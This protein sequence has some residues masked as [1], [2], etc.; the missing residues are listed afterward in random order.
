VR[1][2]PRFASVFFEGRHHVFGFRE[3]P[4]AFE[5]WTTKITIHPDPAKRSKYDPRGEPDPIEAVVAAEARL[6]RYRT[7]ISLLRAGELESRASP[8]TAGAVEQITRAIWSHTEFSFDPYTGNI[9]QDNPCSTADHDRY[10]KRWVG[11]VLQK[12]TR[13][14][15]GA[16]ASSSARTQARLEQK[17]PES[18]LRSHAPPF[19]PADVIAL[20]SLSRA[21]DHLVFNHPEIRILCQIAVSVADARQIPFEEDAGLVVQVLGYD[22][23]ALPLRYFA[24]LVEQPDEPPLPESP[25]EAAISAEY[26]GVELPPDVQAYYDAVKL[27]ADTLIG[28]LQQQQVVARGHTMD[29]HLVQIAHSIWSHLE[30]YVHPPT[31]DVYNA[32]TRPMTK[33]WSG[34]V[35]E[36]PAEPQFHVKPTE[37]HGIRSTSTENNAGAQPRRRK[38]ASKRRKAAAK[39]GKA[40]AERR[41]TPAQASIEQAVAALWPDGVPNTMLL[42]TR[43]QMIARWQ[44]GN[45]VLAVSSKTVR[46]FLT[47]DGRFRE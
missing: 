36:A 31:G 23:P 24:H 7:L 41:K 16:N 11:V 26:F 47:A 12:P 44:K 20:G 38:T 10:I 5:R 34:V 29:G 15:Q 28:M 32:S 1:L 40:A 2:A 14:D 6:H 42:K 39:R 13:A 37:H 4:L 8:G 45:G 22:D 9:L 3:W 18:V 43:D 19:T 25:E 27:R 30:Y 21:L 33:R 46:R 35:L 17:R